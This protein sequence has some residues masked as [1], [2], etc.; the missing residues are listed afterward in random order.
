MSVSLS[1]CLSS[2]SC[3]SSPS[4]L[5][6][7]SE[8]SNHVDSIDSGLENLQNILNAQTFTFDASPLVEVSLRHT[9]SNTLT[10]FKHANNAWA[11]DRTRMYHV[12]SLFSFSVRPV[13]LETSTSTVWTLW[14]QLHALLFCYVAA[15]PHSFK[16]KA[17]HI[18]EQCSH[19]SDCDCFLSA[20]V[21]WSS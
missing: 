8:L 13:R 9:P 12:N 21:W 19:L 17:H 1:V 2:T 14:V 6:L 7:R 5:S 10:T 15:L 16:I 4:C 20:A 11:C 18:N 3:L